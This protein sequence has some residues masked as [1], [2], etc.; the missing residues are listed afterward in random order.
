MRDFTGAR[1]R[2]TLFLFVFLCASSHG[3]VLELTNNSE[4]NSG[5]TKETLAYLDAEK[6]TL[7]QPIEPSDKIGAD[8]KFV[9]VEVVEVQNPK[10]YT[11]TFKVEYQPKDTE[12]VFLGSFSLYPSDNPGK[13][14]VPTLGKVR[15]QGAIVLSVVVPDNFQR[16]DVLRVGVRRIK[17]L[18]Q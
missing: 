17:F 6:P 1:K 10:R 16:G 7:I 14:I 11:A 8:C 12:R 15:N 9:Q 5:N 3:R 4:R 2:W 18:K 13:F